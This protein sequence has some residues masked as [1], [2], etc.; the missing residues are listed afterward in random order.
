[1]VTVNKRELQR[2]SLAG[3]A[4]WELL[5]APWFWNY[6]KNGEGEELKGKTAVQI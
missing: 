3:S 5:N 1:M 6:P 2:S 4:F